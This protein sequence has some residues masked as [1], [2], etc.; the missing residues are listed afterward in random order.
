[1][2]AQEISTLIQDIQYIKMA[3]LWLLMLNML[4]MM[5]TITVLQGIIME[6]PY[7]GKLNFALLVSVPNS[8]N[9]PQGHHK[10]VLGCLWP[11]PPQVSNMW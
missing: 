9:R 2:E 6:L 11:P 1:M 3:G 8:T 7:R 5:G 10:G 4:R